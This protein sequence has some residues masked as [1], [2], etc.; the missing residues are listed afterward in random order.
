[1][2]RTL[3]IDDEP[4]AVEI[5]ETY[6]K[7]IPELQLHG[8]CYNAI[9]ANRLIQTEAVDLIFADIQMPQMTGIELMR[10]LANP[11]LVIF[12]TA[13]PEFAVEG[14]E[15]NA[16]DYLLKPIAFDRFLKSVN[17][18]MS[19]LGS[20]EK[21]NDKD[22]E[23][24]DF[25][26]VKADKKLVKLQYD[27][28]LFIEGLKDY[29]IIYTDNSRIVTLQ[30]MK[31]LEEKLPEQFFVRVHRSYI[32]NLEKINSIHSDD[33]EMIVKG[34]AKQIPIGNNYA[35]HFNKIIS[36]KRI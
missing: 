8:K 6:V 27:E 15:L 23:R 3:I 28:I 19:K 7:Q 21:K 30:T 9:D 2:I 34:Q 32:V 22:L 5:L 29:V 4:L 36:K 25:I 18:A 35:D 13:Y 33:I 14:F 24:Q 17:K 20:L 31:S 26:F 1:M 10:S 12:T 16:V 11:P